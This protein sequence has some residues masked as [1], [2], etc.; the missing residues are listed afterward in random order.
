[1]NAVKAT[2]ADTARNA[3][4]RNQTARNY[5]QPA[6]SRMKWASKAKET[7]D[8]IEKH[9]AEGYRAGSTE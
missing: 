8:V 5:A 4:G 2:V 6:C 3:S 7:A 9:A 1:V